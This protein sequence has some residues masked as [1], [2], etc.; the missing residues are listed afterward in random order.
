MQSAA[1]ES[2]Q[3]EPL[4]AGVTARSASSGRSI[5]HNEGGARGNVS[6]LNTK[7]CSR[8][9]QQGIL[10]GGGRS[11]GESRTDTRYERSVSRLDKV[12]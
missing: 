11:G 1:T 4:V 6:R 8:I 7:E 5:N 10:A 2:H 3:T 12:R 9:K